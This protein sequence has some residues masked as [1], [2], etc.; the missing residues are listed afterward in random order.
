MAYIKKFVAV[1]LNDPIEISLLN[2]MLNSIEEEFKLISKG[3]SSHASRHQADGGDPLNNLL[4][5]ASPYIKWKSGDLL[6]QTDEGTNTDTYVDIKGRG[7]GRG[8]LRI[9]DQDSAEH[10][11]ITVFNGTGY[12]GVGG[13]SP[14]G[15]AFQ[16]AVPQDIKCWAGII[17][18]NPCFIR[19]GYKTAV[20]VK[21]LRDYVDSGG[22][23]RIEGEDGVTL[24]QS[25]G[26]LGFYGLATPIALQTGVAVTAAGIHAALVNLGLITA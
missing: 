19:C 11:A 23:A 16:Y 21:Y 22:F 5:G 6:F 3:I 14:Q 2:K 26:K 1:R 12:I 24:A 15:L 7:S 10:I 4:L 17:S 9:F 18:G 8:W 20:G 25:G 13:A